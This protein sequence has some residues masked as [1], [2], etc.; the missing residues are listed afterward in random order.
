MGPDGL[1]G[2]GQMIHVG[3]LVKIYG[4]E[5]GMKGFTSFPGKHG[6]HTAVWVGEGRGLVLEKKD[7]F[8][9]VLV[10]GRLVW[11]EEYQLCRE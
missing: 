8:Y 1:V 9:H 10:H 4:R 3:D 2:G 7:T 5:P 6:Y 11:F